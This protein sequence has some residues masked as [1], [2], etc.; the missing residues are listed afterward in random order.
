MDNELLLEA[1]AAAYFY[2][3]CLVCLALLAWCWCLVFGVGVCGPHNQG[4][5]NCGSVA[6]WSASW[7]GPLAPRFFERQSRLA[8]LCVS[9]PLPLPDS[10][11]PWLWPF[12]FWLPQSRI[13]A[14]VCALAALRVPDWGGR[15]GVAVPFSVFFFCLIKAVG[16]YFGSSKP[17]WPYSNTE[18]RTAVREHLELVCYP[19]VH[20]PCAR[21]GA[22]E[23]LELPSVSFSITRS[24]LFALLRH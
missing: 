17:V 12:G 6:P 7:R 2:F 19:S 8:P 21:H 1:G 9:C 23:G 4:G 14:A 24:P 11:W 20:A 3:Y 16:Y 5:D 15:G 22:A 13:L 18:H 10:V